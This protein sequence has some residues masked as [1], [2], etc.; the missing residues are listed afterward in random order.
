V[1]ILLVLITYVYDNARFK[2]RKIKM[3]LKNYNVRVWLETGSCNRLLRLW[4]PVPEVC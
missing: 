1:C 2:K 3:D 4:Y